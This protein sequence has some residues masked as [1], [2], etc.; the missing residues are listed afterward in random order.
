M[1]LGGVHSGS[2]AEQFHIEE[3][4]AKIEVQDG[5]IKMTH[6]D[7][8]EKIFRARV[9]GKVVS[10]E[11]SLAHIV[12]RLKTQFGEAEVVT[13][14]HKPISKDHK[15]SV[16][17]GAEKLVV[18]HE[19][20]NEIQKQEI[21][22][23][24]VDE[25][26]RQILHPNADK[27][28]STPENEEPRT[29]LT[30]PLQ[31]TQEKEEV[32]T[33][34][35]TPLS[36]INEGETVETKGLPEFTIPTP[37]REPPATFQRPFSN[38]ATMMPN[39]FSNP[40]SAIS[41]PSP[42]PPAASRPSIPAGQ[43]L[44]AKLDAQDRAN[45]KYEAKE[46]NLSEILSKD[47]QET[48]LQSVNNEIDRQPKVGGFSP[49]QLFQ[50]TFTSQNSAAFGSN[51][52]LRKYDDEEGTKAKFDTVVTN[53]VVYLLNKDPS[54]TNEAEKKAIVRAAGRMQQISDLRQRLASTDLNLSQFYHKTESADY[55]IANDYNPSK[56]TDAQRKE[57]V[58]VRDE[59]LQI[60][61][62]QKTRIDPDMNKGPI[63]QSLS[64]ILDV[65]TKRLLKEINF[66]L[67]DIT[68]EQYGL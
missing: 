11:K 58:A 15:V 1:S 51:V 59:L 66:L 62:D 18:R 54:I 31:V 45:A 43:S 48:A 10:D 60:A 21:L 63:A 49:G 50:G 42:I 20:G 16:I 26:S 28:S 5:F 14:V 55:L 22:A 25:V 37:R 29:K 46:G 53:T 56:L 32:V 41:V 7:G 35:K 52:L 13:A 4:K 38:P 17:I 44:W 24:R 19:A 23:K 61:K 9:G 2:G 6:P 8:S 40:P 30:L 65:N 47:E 12:E 64:G 39:V 36:I 27:T 34:F 3:A 57:L 33:T 68:R 67:G